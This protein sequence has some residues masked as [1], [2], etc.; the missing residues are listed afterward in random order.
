VLPVLL[1]SANAMA[2]T[3]NFG[4]VSSYTQARQGATIQDGSSGATPNAATFS[5][6]RSSIVPSGTKVSVSASGSGSEL[7]IV[8]TSTGKLGAEPATYSNSS[9]T[10]TVGAA[11]VEYLFQGLLSAS[12]GVEKLNVYYN[13]QLDDVTGPTVSVFRRSHFTQ[14]LLASPS[15]D[16]AS[17]ANANSTSTGATSGTLLSGRVYKLTVEFGLTGLDTSSGFTGLSTASLL[18]DPPTANVIPSPAAA[19]GGAALLLGIAGRRRR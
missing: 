11:D 10:F 15:L 5:F 6:S 3:V 17:A 1:V 19:M 13:I 16:L 7:S 14:G 4:Q 8:D 2:A 12:S 9:T 18:F